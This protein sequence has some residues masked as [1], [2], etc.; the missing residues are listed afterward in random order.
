[1]RHELADFVDE[2]FHGDFEAGRWA[3]G[4][5]AALFCIENG[6]PIPDWLIP[7]VAAALKHDALC[8]EGRGR[9]KTYPL[10]ESAAAAEVAFIAWE[11]DRISPPM[12]K[13][14]AFKQVAEDLSRHR[15]KHWT[16]EMVKTRYY[17]N[18]SCK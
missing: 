11:V 14:N 16:A 1:M 8:A 9:G 17:R 6:V 2:T 3:K 18:R 7:T 10:A 4:Y 15:T 13:S 12:P 5:E